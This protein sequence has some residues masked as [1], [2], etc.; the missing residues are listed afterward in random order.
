[1]FEYCTALTSLIIPETVTSIGDIAF[2]L[3][4]ALE[5]LQFEGD[6]PSL[7]N[8]VFQDVNSDLTIYYHADKSGWI[9]P[10]WNGIQTA[11]W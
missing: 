10:T 4:S 1:V 9:T 5:S 8:N 11:T 7:G 2:A 6:A 3:C